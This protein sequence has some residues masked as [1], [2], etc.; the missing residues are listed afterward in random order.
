MPG[1]KNFG[2]LTLP[3]LGVEGGLNPLINNQTLGYS[4]DVSSRSTLI[5]YSGAGGV[6]LAFAPAFDLGNG[7]N[8]YVRND[9]ATAIT[10]DPD[11]GQLINGAATL[12]LEPGQAIQ[13]ICTGSAFYTVGQA[14]SV[15]GANQALSNLTSPTAINQD[16]LSG[17]DLAPN[18]G[19]PNFRFAR[20]YTAGVLTGEDNGDTLDLVA[21]DTGTLIETTMMRFTAGNPAAGE[22]RSPVTA[23]T[24]APGTNNTQLAT[25]A[26]VQ[27]AVGAGG[28]VAT[29]NGTANRITSSGGANPIIDIAATYVGQNSITTLGTVTTGVW[30][31]TV[32]DLS[33]GGTNANLTA[34]NG[35][36]LYSTATAGAI[37]A[38]TATA[39]QML[40]SGATAAPAWSTA[41]WPAT[42]TANQ[43]LYSSGTNTVTGLTTANSSVLVTSG[44]GVPSLSTTLPNGIT[45]TTQSAADNSTKVATTAYADNAGANKTL[46]NLTAPTAISQGLIPTGDLSVAIGSDAHRWGSIRASTIGSGLTGVF[47]MLVYDTGLANYVSAFQLTVGNPATAVLGT[48][49]TATTQPPG[50]NTNQLA[51]TAFVQA[52][53]AGGVSYPISLSNGGTNA[54]LTASNGG[55]FYSTATAGAILA[56]T[57][58]ARQMLQSGATGAPAWSTATYPATTTANQ[59]LYSSATNTVAGLATAN[60]SV[61][62][63]SGAGVPSLSTALPNGITANTQAIATA[64]T[65]V[66]TTGFVDSRVKLGQTNVAASSNITFTQNVSTNQY[67]KITVSS[68]CTL[69]FTFDSGLVESMCLQLINAGA[70]TVTWSSVLWAGGAAPTFTSSGTDMVVIWHNGD[71]IIYGALIGKAFA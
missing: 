8:V 40:Q 51:T 71:N 37:L 69:A 63:T 46:S 3:V 25:T 5:R 29:V 49:V 47:D 7:W 18:I 33:H 38:G 34:S 64:D 15:D 27:A 67:F 12:S 31:G 19:A 6:T 56:G 1:L 17:V 30:N 4:A 43:I 42:T 54:N 11:G 68:N 45:A 26:F 52:A 23:V 24:Q 70:F 58:T 20:T 57:A 16:L 21:Y 2:I 50:T 60:S 22:I 59:I 41:T 14:A 13:V 9:A 32:V 39:R 36:I 28:F 53:V 65:T 66:A 55:I 44:A 48:T 35:G 62:V 10:L 61:L